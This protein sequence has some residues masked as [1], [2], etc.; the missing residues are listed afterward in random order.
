MIFSRKFGVAMDAASI[1]HGFVRT[2][3]GRSRIVD[4]PGSPYTQLM[5]INERGDVVGFYQD[6]ADFVL[7]GFV[8]SDGRFEPVAPPDAV[9][10]AYPY[11]ITDDG[12]IVGWALDANFR[13][14]G[15]VATPKA[16]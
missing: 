6:P 10:G 12:R 15:F 2:R 9:N 8:W 16:R 11:R 3:D 7:K 13:T 4:V 14:I 5:G 1:Y